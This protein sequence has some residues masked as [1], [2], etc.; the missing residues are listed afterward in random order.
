[1]ELKF[2]SYDGCYPCLCMGTLI[3]NLDGRNIQFPRGC[4][5]SGGN[6]W[7]D[8]DWNDHVE[9]GDWDI[10][11]YPENF[12]EELKQKAIELINENIPQGCCGGCV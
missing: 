1:M 5:I 7:F 3:M 10:N 4:L 9:S 11:E 6:V 12:P 2:V 8:D